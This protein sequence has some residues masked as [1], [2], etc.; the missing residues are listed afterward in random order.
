MGRQPAPDD[1][2]VQRSANMRPGNMKPSVLKH[3]VQ[4]T[5]VLFSFFLGIAHRD[6]KSVRSPILDGDD[7]HATQKCE[8]H[9]RDR[10]WTLAR[11][12]HAGFISRGSI[13]P[14]RLVTREWELGLRLRD[15]PFNGGLASSALSIGLRGKQGN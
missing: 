14:V 7:E 9:H 11:R 12:T 13:S 3:A 10:L 4:L 6:C 5:P 1:D 2:R 15:A 8:H